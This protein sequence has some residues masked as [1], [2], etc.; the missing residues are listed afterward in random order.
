[1]RATCYSRSGLLLLF[2]S[3]LSGCADGGGSTS[4]GGTPTGPDTQAPTVSLTAPGNSSAVSGV[5]TLQAIASD[6]V[7]VAGV[8]FRLDGVNMGTEDLSAPFELIWDTASAVNGAHQVTAVA[9]D[10]VG[11]VATSSPVNVTVSNPASGTTIAAA[12]CSAADVQSAINLAQD[13]YTVTVPAG[14]CAW[15]SGVS[16]AGKGIHLRGAGA[17][18]VI[19]RSQSP[20]AIGTGSKT[21]TT[22]SGLPIAAGQTLRV[23]RTGGIVSG[24]T[25]TGARGYMVGTVTSY[26]GTTL[27]LNIASAQGTGTHPVW[28]ISTNAAT[29][30]EHAAAGSVLMSLMEDAS[31]NVEVSGMRFVNVSGTNDFVNMN[32]SANGRLILIHDMYFEATHGSQDAIQS[33]TNQGVIW[34]SS[35]VAMPYSRAQLAIH[36]VAYGA[37]DSWI[38]ASTMGTADPTGTNN[39]YIE[40]CDFH[41]WLNATDFDNNAHSTTRRSLFNNAGFG[42]HG[43][44]TSTHGQRHFEFYDNEMTF[45]GFSDGQTLPIARGFYLRGGTGVIAD[46]IINMPGGSDYPGKLGIDMTVM[47]LQRSGGPNPCWG[48]GI[49]GPQYPAPRQV[50]MGRITGA[51]GNDSVTYA[52]DSEPLYIWNNIGSFPIGTTDFGDPACVNPDSTPSYVVV[53]RDYIVGTPKPGYAKYPYPH[54][55]RGGN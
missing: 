49:P 6:N 26:I 21:F 7:G 20:V 19:G 55:L 17:G 48:A 28:I 31:H 13:G 40:D 11:N 14:T 2:V 46:N 50:G 23:E 3:L 37:T 45:N 30:I 8:Q 42:T 27:T 4:G 12:T 36:L 18:R 22:Q 33:D 5:F 1:M 54:P 35:F 39:L 51:A 32:R 15:A 44:D 53:G 24:G 38:R 47:N 29:T 43:A 41:G 25:T 52:G 10:A 34:N 16:I 9:R